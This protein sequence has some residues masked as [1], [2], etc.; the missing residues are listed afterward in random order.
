MISSGREGGGE[1]AAR[2]ARCQGA[3]RHAVVMRIGT[4]VLEAAVGEIHLS[5]CLSPNRM[6][7]GVLFLAG[8]KQISINIVSL[9]FN[10][11]QIIILITSIYKHCCAIKITRF[12][13]IF[14]T[15]E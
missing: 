8:I 7:S 1:V 4:E 15:N 2:L 10:A 11:D 9:S 6:V 3:A 13:K 5:H 12:S 14:Q